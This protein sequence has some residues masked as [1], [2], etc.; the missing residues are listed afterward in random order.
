MLKL[1]QEFP[2]KNMTRLKDTTAV[3]YA[4]HVM[5]LNSSTTY[6]LWVATNKLGILQAKMET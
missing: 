4:V 5:L 2:N 3:A 6:G 1:V